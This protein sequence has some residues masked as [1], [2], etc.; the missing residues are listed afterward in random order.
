MSNDL[1][2][3]WPLYNAWPLAEE[4]AKLSHVYR[5]CFMYW[6]LSHTRLTNDKPFLKIITILNH[7]LDTTCLSLGSPNNF[8]QK[9]NQLLL[10]KKATNFAPKKSTNLAPKKSTNLAPKKSTKP[11]PKKSTLSLY[12]QFMNTI[13]SIYQIRR[14]YAQISSNHCLLAF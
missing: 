2:C 6:V 11:T 3:G 7:K 12:R 10:P 8:S 14:S 5:D 9:E 1:L 13:T 4:E